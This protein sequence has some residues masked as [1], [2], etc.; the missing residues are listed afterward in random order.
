[1]EGVCLYFGNVVVVFFELERG[2]WWI[3]IGFMLKF[4][5]DIGIYRVFLERW[6][7]LVFVFV[8]DFC[9]FLIGDVSGVFVL[10]IEKVVWVVSWRSLSNVYSCV[11]GFLLVRIFVGSSVGCSC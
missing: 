7:V 4:I 9:V 2:V 1:M 6:G 11:G 5:V 10:V 3:Y 8:G